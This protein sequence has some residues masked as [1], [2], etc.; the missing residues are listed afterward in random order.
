MRAVGSSAKEGRSRW[1]PSRLGCRV[2]TDRQTL[3]AI[4]VLLSGEVEGQSGEVAGVYGIDWYA[5][6]PG[7]EAD[8]VQCDGFEGE[9]RTVPSWPALASQPPLEDC[10]GTGS[11]NAGGE[12]AGCG[13]PGYYEGDADDIEP[14]NKRFHPK[15]GGP[16]PGSY[17]YFCREPKGHEGSC[18][19]PAVH[20]QLL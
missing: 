19:C 10:E 13:G 16:D 17:W 18:D 4:A 6:E 2:C 12:C 15:G 8:E 9:M 11:A 5:V 20:E 3:L 7:I 1:P 14:C